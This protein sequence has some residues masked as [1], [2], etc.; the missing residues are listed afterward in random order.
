MSNF[1]DWR[2][3]KNFIFIVPEIVRT[4]NNL[5]RH[6]LHQSLWGYRLFKFLWMYCRSAKRPLQFVTCHVMPN[7]NDLYFLD[8]CML[9]CYMPQVSFP[10]ATS[11][12]ND[13]YL[14]RYN[15]TV[16]IVLYFLQ[17]MKADV[18][19]LTLVFLCG[20]VL[21]T[22]ACSCMRTHPQQQYCKSDFGKWK[23]YARH[24]CQKG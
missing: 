19:I 12:I 5:I 14:W 3:N 21:Y 4:K 22:D 2:G 10:E 7:P 13:W 20:L 6:D 16:I 11:S 9:V 18:L 15:V 23:Q 24:L 17:A 8:L 1:S